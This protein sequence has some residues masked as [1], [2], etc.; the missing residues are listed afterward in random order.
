MFIFVLTLRGISSAADPINYNEAADGDLP[1]VNSWL[2]NPQF[3]TLDL[4]TNTISGS[5]TIAFENPDHESDSD[6]IAFKIPIDMML[7]TIQIS[8][9]NPKGDA[10][11]D[12]ISLETTRY[13][14][15]RTFTSLDIWLAGIIPFTDKLGTGS[16][17]PLFEG[18]YAI[19]RSGWSGGLSQGQYV[20]WD[21]SLKFIIA[22]KS[23]IV[24]IPSITLLLKNK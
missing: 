13:E 2:T 8:V 15:N 7:R 11:I 24:P 23:S 4:G 19:F 22:K 1:D 3:F 16:D 12:D 17:I 21:Y 6:L 5:E 18:Q 20:Q 10:F 9:T 14:S